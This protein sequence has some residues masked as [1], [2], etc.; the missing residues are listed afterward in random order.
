MVMNR[1]TLFTEKV[2]VD[3]KPS[4]SDSTHRSNS[5]NGILF[6]EYGGGVGSGECGILRP[7]SCINVFAPFYGI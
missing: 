2:L 4:R 3:Y 7:Y 6:H 1:C 5:T